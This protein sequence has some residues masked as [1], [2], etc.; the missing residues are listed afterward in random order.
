MS[1]A[2]DEQWWYDFYYR[3]EQQ[4]QQDCTE[5]FWSP[6]FF[7][8]TITE[9]TKLI[10]WASLKDENPVEQIENL[11]IDIICDDLTLRQ[12]E[13]LKKVKPNDTALTILTLAAEQFIIERQIAGKAVNSILAGYPW[14]L[15]WGR[16]AFI[17][18]PG[19]LLST[20][21]FTEAASVLTSFAS[22]VSQGMIPNRFDDYTNAAHYNSIDASLWFVSAAFEYYK[23][24]GNA[25]VF[26][27]QLLP[28]IRWIVDSYHSGT[29]FNIHADEDGLIFGGDKDTQLTW[30]DAK[31]NGIAFT[32]RW[33][34]A[35]E[36]NALWYNAICLLAQFYQEKDWNSAHHFERLA[37]KVQKSFCEKFWN[38]STGCLYDCIKAADD[39]DPSV[40]P[41]QI[42]AVSLPNSPLDLDRQKMVVEKVRSELLTPYGL[43]TLSPNDKNYK[44]RYQGGFAQRDAAYHQGTVWPFLTG[45]FIEAY[46][47]VNDYSRP[48][49]RTAMEFIQ[50]L[51]N[52]LTQ[53]GCIGSISEIFDGDEPQRPHGCFAQAW[54]VAELLR[55]Y[56][57]ITS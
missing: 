16:D 52:H 12:N 5:D 56:L 3:I 51:L 49:K 21:R 23:K 34:K 18:L 8:C 54:S 35:V 50:P 40:R 13:L 1:F 39:K 41:N 48:A 20:G 27:Q 15:D 53:A 29:R 37:E 26:T 46:L 10:L 33:G 55:A 36:I 17:S 24:S 57:L 2:Q 45:H 11:D 38:E 28:M 30:M 32:P 4:R 9:P 42:F 25:K 7:R 22:S 44:G 14:F 19:L 43:R 6:G 31:H 47:K